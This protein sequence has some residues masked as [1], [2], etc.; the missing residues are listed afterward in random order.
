M[1]TQLTH[2]FTQLN[3]KGDD[4]SRLLI[5]VEYDTKKK[6]W[7]QLI[8]VQSYD[9]KTRTATD[10]THIFFNCFHEQAEEI[11]NKIDWWREYRESKEVLAA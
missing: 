6:E 7:T 11:V 5:T 4:Q 3:S 8:S 10:L 2:V 1:L 9:C